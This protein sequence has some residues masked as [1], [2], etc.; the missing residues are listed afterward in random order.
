MRARHLVPP[1]ALGLYPSLALYAANL[2]QVMASDVLRSTLIGAALGLALVMAFFWLRRDGDRSALL[3]CACLMLFYSYGHVH[4]LLQPVGVAGLRL[5]RHSLLLSLWVVLALL[6]AALILRT[7]R[8][9]SGAVAVLLTAA[10]ILLALPSAQI[11]VTAVTSAARRSDLSELPPAP[12]LHAP[13]S[14]PDVYY[15]I[16]DGYGRADIL[17]SLYGFDN[18]PFLGSLAA[19]GFIVAD[20]AHSNYAQTLLSLGSSLGMTHLSGFA[21]SL[22]PASR[23]VDALQDYIRHG[24]VRQA[25]EGLGYRVVAFETGYPYTNIYDADVF[26]RTSAVAGALPGLNPFEGMLFRTT[27]GAVLMDAQFL[28]GTAL[29]HLVFQSEFDRHR[30]RMEGILDRLSDLPDLRG[31]K[32]VFAH[33]IA[34][35]PPFVYGPQGEP[36]Q[37]LQ[38]FTTLDAQ[39]Y[40]GTP[41]AY[42]QGYTDQLIYLNARLDQVLAH[43]LERSDPAPVVILQGDH[44]PGS[45]FAGDEPAQRSMPERMS[46]LFAVHLGGRGDAAAIYPSVTPVNTFPLVF[47]QVFGAGLPLLPDASY[48]SEM[49]SPY[50]LQD[51]NAELSLSPPAA[52][53]CAPPTP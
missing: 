25:L 20:R 48:Y 52:P 42:R 23:N 11:G 7:R 4:S 12:A 51:V 1:I 28:R 36:V 34:P 8:S 29:G 3:A 39:N 35:H 41:E 30:Q 6:A 27:L 10:L 17:C 43:I 9:L 33:I 50:A 19:Q 24:P 18:T 14:L 46:I 44:G 16:L 40:P 31:P 37:P 13:P 32:F 5:G 2:G 26:Y 49:E 21:D 38:T 53:V 47:N 45:T 22:G 15:I